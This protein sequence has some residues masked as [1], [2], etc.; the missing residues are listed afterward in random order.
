[1]KKIITLLLAV[2]MVMSFAACNTGTTPSSSTPAGGEGE[3]EAST[4]SVTHSLGTV[5]VP[6]NPQRVVVLDLAVLDIVDALGVGDKVVGMPKDTAVSYLAA[7]YENGEVANLGSVKEV[8]MEM[9]NSLEP[10]VIFIGARLASEYENILEIAPTILVKADNNA[11]MVSFKENVKMV[12]SIFE[13]DSLADELL[14]GF[15]ARVAA[16]NEVAAGKNAVVGIVTSGSFSTLGNGSRCSLIVNE[17][18]F[19]NVAA[20][21]DSTHGNET[22]FE[23]LLDQ[24]PD[25]IFVLDRDS[26]IKTEGAQLA[27]EIMEN[28]IVMKT[29]A[30]ENGNIVY[31]TPDVW[32]LSEGG[33]T[34]TDVMLK[35]LEA[36]VLAAE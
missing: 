13:K 1:M 2:V 35:D 14:A 24:N 16:V 21:V 15:D 30:F 34:A 20:D 7:Y 25:Y 17:A 28:E 10:E 19:V 11:Y 31:L 33:I 4:I 8:D 9:L 18:G 27:K 26:A 5:E 3:G 32:Y 23:Y 6:V 12:A 29:T 36:G 22:S